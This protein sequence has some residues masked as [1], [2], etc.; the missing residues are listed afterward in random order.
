MSRLSCC[1]AITS[2]LLTTFST[3][4]SP[5]MVYLSRISSS[6]ALEGYSMKI[7]SRNR[8]N[9]ASGKGKVPSISMGFCVA[10]MKKGLS[11]R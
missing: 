3:A 5:R 11:R 10:R 6:S 4:G 1:R 2:S 8:S 9:C 7:L